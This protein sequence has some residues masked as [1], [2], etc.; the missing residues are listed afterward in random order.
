MD[1]QSIIHTTL[2]F[3]GQYGLWGIFLL[4]FLENLGLPLPTEVGFIVGQSMVISSSANYTEVFSIILLGKTAGSIV[5]YFLGR[6]FADRIHLINQ[7]SSRLKKAQTIFAKWM[8]KYGDFA[9]FI[10]RLVGYIRPWSSY[11]TGIGEIKVL[12]FLFY[13]ILGSAV[14]I[15][16]T[17]LTLSGAVGLWRNY[18]FLR[19]F[20]IILFFI[21]FFGFWI[22]LGIYNRIKAKTRK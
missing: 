13:N 17:M 5:S 21:F 12:P 9:V 11:L 8:K 10:S 20:S 14:I 7:D 2:D 3:V 16:I 19:P 15:L 22:G 6:Y 1:Y 4:M 18:P